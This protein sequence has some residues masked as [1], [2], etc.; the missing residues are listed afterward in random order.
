MVQRRGVHRGLLL[1]VHRL[2]EIDL[3]L[4]RA[5][6]DGANVFIHILAL[7]FEGSGD[8]QPEHVDP[9]FLQALLVRSADGDLLDA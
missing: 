6:A 8:L 9:E 5:A 4:E 1:G 2:H 7:A 3:D